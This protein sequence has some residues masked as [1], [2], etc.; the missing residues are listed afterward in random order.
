MKNYK[1][2]IFQIDWSQ[3][4]QEMVIVKA[5][6]REKAEAFLKRHKDLGPR[7]VSYYGEQ[8]KI[9]EVN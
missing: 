7:Y 6:S 1:Y 3:T 5:E 4:D 2:Y 9:V 8:D